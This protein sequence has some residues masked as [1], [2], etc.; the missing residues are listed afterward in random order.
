MSIGSTTGTQVFR[1]PD[2]GEG[3]T[4]AGLV[5]WLV[6]VG[7]TISPVL[8][9]SDGDTVP[10]WPSQRGKSCLTRSGTQV[11]ETSA[12]MLRL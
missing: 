11:Q 5:Q 12:W 10:A 7:D 8:S 4:E 9:M 6:S 3:L 1:L 2:L